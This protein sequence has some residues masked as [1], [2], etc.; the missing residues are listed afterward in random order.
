MTV[1]TSNCFLINKAL[2][3]LRQLAVLSRSEQILPSDP[4]APPKHRDTSL[5][6]GMKTQKIP[7]SC[8]LVAKIFP[9][10]HFDVITYVNSNSHMCSFYFHAFP[11]MYQYSLD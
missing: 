1:I 5:R 2:P 4:Q 9:Y 7:L 11:A 10:V 8:A 6:L 3:N